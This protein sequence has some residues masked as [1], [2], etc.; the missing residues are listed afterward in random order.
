MAELKTTKIKD[1]K[2]DNISNDDLFNITS[3]GADL[4]FREIISM[5]E[6]DELVKPDL[7]RKYVW[8][9]EEAS[10]FIDSILLGL[11][12]PSIFLAK[13]QEETKLIVDGYQRIMTV[14]DFCKGVFSDTKKNFKLSNTK[15]IN[16]TWRNKTFAELST[17]EQR[18][19]RSTTIHAIIFEQKKPL[20][21]SGMYQVFERINTSGR[22]LN[23]QEIRNCVYYGKFNN[24]IM[25]LNKEVTWRG[26]LNMPLEDSRMMDVEYILRF[27]AMKDLPH[28]TEKSKKQISLKKY[29]NIYMGE[30]NKMT[31][32]EISAYEEHF[33]TVMSFLSRTLG[34]NSFRNVKVKD[35][36]VIGFVEKLHPTIFDAIC[37]ATSYVVTNNSI[38]VFSYVIDKQKHLELLQDEDFIDG[39]KNRTT[40]TGQILKRAE[41]ACEYLYGVSYGW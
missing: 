25:R 2:N 12:V 22:T 11:P 36:E 32:D 9:H 14:Y 29:L 6:D 19:I 17:E 23:P 16:Q 18:K 33:K 34:E 7:Q 40:N 4:S 8:S 24:F 31:D 3:W 38:D 26:L 27:F 37:M 21:D 1:E 39:I 15:A 30:K 20:N 28:R 35:K 10:K 13:T 5:Y 41:K